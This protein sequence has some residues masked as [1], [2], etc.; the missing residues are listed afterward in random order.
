M[1]LPDSFLQELLSRSDIESVVSSYVNVKRRG[2]NLVGLCPFHGEKTP[3]F[4][5]YPETASFYC[6][7]CGAGG[8]VITFIKRIENLDYIDAVK[9]LADRAGMKM[10]ENDV[11]D[12][13]SRLRLR[14]LEANREAARWFHSNLYTP[15]GRV[16]LE[17]F[18]SRGYTDQTIRRFGLGYAPDSFGAL[19]DHMR[20]K[21]Y[22]DEELTAAWLAARGKKSGGIYDIFRARAM[23]PI[24][25]IRGNVIAFGGRVLDDSK[26]KYL[27][28]ADTLA[29]KKTNNLFALNFAKSSG[30]K[31]LILCEG[32]MDVIALHQAGFTNAVAALGTSF[33]AEHA[34]LI[35]RYAE[36]VILVFDAD[37]AGQKGTQRAIGLLRQTGVDIRVIS[38]PDG[39]DPDEFIK[40][41]GPERFRLLLERSANDVEYRLIALGKRHMLGTAD[42][43]VAYL[44]EAAALLAE[45]QSPIER[46]VYAGKLSAE[47]GVNKSA[48][49]DQ[50]QELMERRKKQQKSRQLSQ[51]VRN[52][53]NTIKK[54]NPD[55]AAH[56]RAV[57]AEEGLL[58]LLLLNPDYIGR[59]AGGLPPE[60]F[61]T[62][63]NRGLYQRLIQ[64]YESGQ[65]V[66]LAFLSADYAGD[67]MGYISRMIRDARERV[68]SLEEAGR[69]ARVIEEEFRLQSLNDPRGMSDEK[70]S[71][72]L[73]A[74]RKAKGGQSS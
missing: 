63:F 74:L 52:T 36:E 31:Q 65:P 47:L 61:A 43:K 10:P 42:G 60:M 44:R 33:T 55:A 58:G 30:G 35:A 46:D 32:Y 72:V 24:I 18:R 3:S 70:I 6:F 49:L 50:V 53:E 40:H 1:P 41:H 62:D 71:E 2:R 28:T 22:K 11:N 37:S 16:G 45:L 19:R 73:E 54:A 67:G 29:F 4:T 15:D 23:V 25:D 57:S 21:G 14:I 8:D 20:G 9:F 13:A 27:N 39:K 59:I 51:I 69:Y 48:I 38:I 64:R 17:Y 12:A 34:R 56:P 5:V 66:D 68:N 26:P 7:G